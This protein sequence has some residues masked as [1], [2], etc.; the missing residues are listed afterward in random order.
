M[1][2]YTKYDPQDITV[3]KLGSWINSQVQNG[4]S[5]GVMQ[6]YG[7]QK[8]KNGSLKICLKLK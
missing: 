4:I 1:N 7:P 2:N 6:I 8:N 5:S 3:P